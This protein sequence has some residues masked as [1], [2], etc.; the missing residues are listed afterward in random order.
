MPIHGSDQ[1]FVLRDRWQCDERIAEGGGK[2]VW[3]AY[4]RQLQRP[5][6]IRILAPPEIDVPRDRSRLDR[7][8]AVAATLR[9]DNVAHLYD[10]FEEELGTVLVGELVE[11][12]SLRELSDRLA[13]LPPDA[14]AAVGIQLADGAADIHAAG[15]AHRDLVPQNVRVTHDGRLKILGLGEA[16]LLAD[17]GA[18]PAIGLTEGSPYLAPEQLEGT[19]SDERTDIYAI[20]LMLWELA[21]GDPPFDDEDPLRAMELRTR[22]DLPALRTGWPS[23][24]KRL[25]RAVETATRRDPAERWQHADALSSALRSDGPGR[26][27]AVL[28]ELARGLLPSPPPPVDSLAS[29]AAYDRP[30]STEGSGT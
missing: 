23:V 15:V 18:T 17:G 6:A 28:R 16:R 13:P 4:D 8:L 30:V 3:R 10:A 29:G 9:Q 14:V 27:H 7:L 21:T 26:P 5:V 24:P 2:S 19:P 11:G 1:P 25:S 22:R 12:P 20:G